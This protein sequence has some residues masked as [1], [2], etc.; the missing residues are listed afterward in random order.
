MEQIS[1]NKYRQ[2]FL[3][4]QKHNINTCCTHIFWVTVNLNLNI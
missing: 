3:S 1:K 2:L 4:K